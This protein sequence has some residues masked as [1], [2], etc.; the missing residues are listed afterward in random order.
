MSTP[1]S[2]HQLVAHATHIHNF[3]LNSAL[4]RNNRDSTVPRGTPSV[5]AIS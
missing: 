5:S 3:F 1:V 2:E 4:A